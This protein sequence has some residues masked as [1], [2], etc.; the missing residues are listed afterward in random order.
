MYSPGC[1]TSALFSRPQLN[2]IRRP[3]RIV[4]RITWLPIGKAPLASW[5]IQMPP[6]DVKSTEGVFTRAVV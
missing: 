6:V 3:V 4:R 2:T 5:R 1:T